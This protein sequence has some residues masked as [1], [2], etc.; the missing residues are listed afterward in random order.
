MRKSSSGIVGL[1]I[2]VL[3]ALVSIIILTAM[4]VFMYGQI[5]RFDE[6]VSWCEDMIID[7]TKEVRNH[8]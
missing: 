1:V 4:M 6:K 3:M 7:L 8:G 5:V 2:L